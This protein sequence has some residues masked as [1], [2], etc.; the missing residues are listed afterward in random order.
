MKTIQHHLFRGAGSMALA[1]LAGCASSKGPD[2]LTSYRPPAAGESLPPQFWNEAASAAGE[3]GYEASYWFLPTWIRGQSTE[4]APSGDSVSSRGATVVNPGLL[5]LP[6]LPLWISVDEQRDG[7]SGKRETNSMS[8]SPLHTSNDDAGWPADEPAIRASGWP[9]LY[10]RFT[11]GTAADAPQL[12]MNNTLW[13]LGPSWGTA[14]LKT[15]DGA[16]KGWFCVPIFAAGLGSLAWFSASFTTPT[17]E[18]TA[19][20][21]LQGWLGYHSVVD[22]EED[23]FS[24]AVVGGVLW[25]DWANAADPEQATDSHHGPLWGMFG[26]GRSDGEPALYLLWIPIK[27]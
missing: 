2:L 15:E 14:D 25:C 8:W 26:W 4:V 3:S 24:R 20:G 11:Y 16:V 5:V 6:W 17:E 21:P 18:V 1:L 10:G 13:T 19:H 23:D 9:L 12:E 27:V 7:K 22:H